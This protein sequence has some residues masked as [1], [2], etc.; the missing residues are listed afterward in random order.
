LIE[1][2][3]TNKIRELNKRVKSLDTVTLFVIEETIL[4]DFVLNPEV[5]RERKEREE[6][7]RQRH[8]VDKQEA[9]T[10]KSK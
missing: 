1:S 5:L 7:K 3:H 8:A 6:R 10:A 9:K 4:E 2:P